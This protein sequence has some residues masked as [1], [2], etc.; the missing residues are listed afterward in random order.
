MAAVPRNL[1]KTIALAARREDVV[2]ADGAARARSPAVH[3]SRGDRQC[4]ASLCH[5]RAVARGGHH[6]PD[7]RARAVRKE[8]RAGGDDRGAAR[9]PGRSRRD[10]PGD[11]GRSLGQR[12]RDIQI[13]RLLGP[14]GGAAR[15]VRAV[16]SAADGAGDRV[17]LYPDGQANGDG[18]R[19]PRRRRLCRKARPCDGG[20]SAGLQGAPL[21]QR[22]FSAAGAALHRRDRRARARDH[23][24][25][26]Q[27]AGRGDK[28]SRFPAP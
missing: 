10:D 12:S 17:W 14:A 24:G 20:A 6:E 9:Q 18:L 25:V 8:H 11:A 7:H 27:G 3:R 26:P 2:A 15:E 22:H 16:R 5:R 19:C 1:S 23:V 13:R 28:R 4:R 21:E